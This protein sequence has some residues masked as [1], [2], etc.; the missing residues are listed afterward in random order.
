MKNFGS[1]FNFIGIT[2]IMISNIIPTMAAIFVAIIVGLI[3]SAGVDNV[4]PAILLIWFYAGGLI[5]FLLFPLKFIVYPIMYEHL[6]NS[7]IIFRFFDKCRTNKRITI[8]T[9]IISGLIDCLFFLGALKILHNCK[10]NILLYLF[11]ILQLG[12][13]TLCMLTLLL[14]FTIRK[15]QNNEKRLILYY[16]LLT[17]LF[18]IAVFVFRY[19]LIN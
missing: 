18:M 19:Y 5:Y 3:Y 14:W 15:S 4:F 16:I 10:S 11:L 12:S 9:I 17:T 8:L 6:D 1:I 2:L 7:D 13:L